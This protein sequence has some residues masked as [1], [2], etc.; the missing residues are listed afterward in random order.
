M[1]ESHA[2]SIAARK[3]SVNTLASMRCVN[4]PGRVFALS[5]NR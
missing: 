4:L 1:T 2:P 5:V 3:G